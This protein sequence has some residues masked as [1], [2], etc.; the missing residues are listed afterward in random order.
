LELGLDLV[1]GPD[2]F[3]LRAV[4]DAGGLVRLGGLDRQVAEEL[5]V[6]DDL[7]LHALLDVVLRADRDARPRLAAGGED[8]LDD[9]LERRGALVSALGELVELDAAV[10]DVTLEL[11]E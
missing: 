3:D 11:V 4:E 1:A 7:E 2:L 5:A 8:A 6:V 10:G 9:A